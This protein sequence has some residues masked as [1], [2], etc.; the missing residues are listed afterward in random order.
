MSLLSRNAPSAHEPDA[1]DGPV[2]VLEDIIA[3]K[4]E[5]AAPPAEVAPGIPKQVVT[6]HCEICPVSMPYDEHQRDGHAVHQLPPPTAKQ[7][8]SI[9]KHRK[10]NAARLAALQP[11]PGICDLCEQEFPAGTV[12]ACSGKPK[13]PGGLKTA[14]EYNLEF[15]VAGL[16]QTLQALGYRIERADGSPA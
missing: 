3:E 4:R 16:V 14:E 7:A 10:A 12:H 9:E 8:A 1:L 6:W 13:D 5:N 15:Q 2:Y 11:P